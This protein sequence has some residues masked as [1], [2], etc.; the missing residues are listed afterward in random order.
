MRGWVRVIAVLVAFGGGAA[1]A[2][3]RESWDGTW[4]GGFANGGSGVQVIFVGDQLIGFFVNGD[5]M[6]DM[7]A[8]LSPSD[9]VVTIT[10]TRGQ[11]VMTRDGPAAA[12]M[13]LQQRGQSDITITLMP[14]H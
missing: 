4:A 14:D 10:W 7:R 2:A 12:H 13:L 3:S 9:G 5:Y 6:I 11:A 1:Q 8:S